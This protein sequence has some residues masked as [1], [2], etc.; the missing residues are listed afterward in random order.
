M[1]PVVA[2]STPAADAVIVYVPTESNLWVDESVSS[3]PVHFNVISSGTA[4][5]S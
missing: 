5:Q 4:F 2:E 1:L 3:V